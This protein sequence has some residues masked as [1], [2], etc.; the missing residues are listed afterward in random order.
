MTSALLPLVVLGPAVVGGGVRAEAGSRGEAGLAAAAGV[1]VGLPRMEGVAAVLGQALHAVAG[2]QRQLVRGVVVLHARGPGGEAAAATF[3]GATAGA[4]GG[5]VGGMPP[6]P[7]E[8]KRERE[9]G[10]CSPG[11]GQSY[12]TA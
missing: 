1:R 10:S 5:G 11:F 12:V 8:T 4:V 3:G 2:P 7:E 6:L 9:V